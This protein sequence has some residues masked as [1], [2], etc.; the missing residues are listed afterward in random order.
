[1]LASTQW[2]FAAD[3][4]LKTSETQPPEGVADEIAATL[5]PKVYEISKGD[6]TL[7]RFWFGKAIQLAYQ[8]TVA[9]PPTEFEADRAL[10]YLQNDAGRFK[11]LCWLLFNLDEF[12][13][14][15]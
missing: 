6:K 14:V 8:L 11:Q 3:F 12:I 10:Q 4:G 13:Y 7:Y 1:M 2:T 5:E 9:R 15:R